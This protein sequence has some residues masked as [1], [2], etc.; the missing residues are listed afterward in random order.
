M[1]KNGQ[2]VECKIT[3]FSG[4]VVAYATH[5]TG[6]DR[7]FVQPSVDKDGKYRDG[8]WLDITT[9]KVL[10]ENAVQLDVVPN[11]EGGPPSAL[12]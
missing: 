2:R 3:G 10:E 11:K 6:C 7:I 4:I 12:K 8:S 9:V 5:L 1:I